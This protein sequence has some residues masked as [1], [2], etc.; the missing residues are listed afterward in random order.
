MSMQ[1]KKIAQ[2]NMAI[3]MA[4]VLNKLAGLSNG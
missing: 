4:N 3:E 2:N 1:G